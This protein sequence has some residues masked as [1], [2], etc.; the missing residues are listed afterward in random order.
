MYKIHKK[1][2]IAVS[3]FVLATCAYAAKDPIYTSYFSRAGAGG[4]DVV[5]YFTDGKAIEGKKRIATEYKEADWYFSNKENLAKFKENP[6][7]YVPQ[8]G[9][10]CAWAVAHGNT[11]SGDPLLWSIVNDKLYLN[12]DENIQAKWASD[13][14]NLIV[15]GDVNWPKV[16][17]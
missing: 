5:S 9:G 11:A 1:I 17:D 6:Q 12:Y 7:K 3:L 13:R 8:Y 16:L 4:Y 10:Y 2:V 14:D 15:L